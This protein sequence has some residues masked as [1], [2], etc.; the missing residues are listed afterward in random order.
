[1]ALTDARLQYAVERLACDPTPVVADRHAQAPA[2][3]AGPDDET[4]RPVGL[5]VL[6]GVLDERLDEERR[7]LHLARL[8][9]CVDLD[10]ELRAEARLLEREVTADVL[11]L[12]GERREL[13]RARERPATV[14]RE[15]EHEL[16]RPVGVRAD[17][18]RDRVQAV[19]EEVWLDLGLERL[20]LRGRRRARRAGELGELQLRRELVPQRGQQ[21]DVA[22]GKRSAVGRVR[23]EGTDRAVAEPERHDRS[24]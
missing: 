20:Q 10:L 24:G 2:A 7:Q 4:K 14:V 9:C 22:V 21:L 19:E 1:A 3:D 12:F 18:A 8:G 23:N 13:A 6:D 17:E 11:E 5:P 15:G 16:S